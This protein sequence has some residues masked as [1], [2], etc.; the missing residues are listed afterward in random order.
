MPSL[1]NA[2]KNIASSVGIANLPNQLHKIVCKKGGKFTL[3]I[4]GN[5]AAALWS[6]CP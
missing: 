3:M 1:T 4:V 2:N 5:V 6:D